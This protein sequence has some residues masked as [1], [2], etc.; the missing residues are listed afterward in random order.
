LRPE[1]MNVKI[2]CAGKTGYAE[3][4]FVELAAILVFTS[5]CVAAISPGSGSRV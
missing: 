3:K 5:I 1:K 4:K 2:L